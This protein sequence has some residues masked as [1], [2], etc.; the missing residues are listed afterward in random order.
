MIVLMDR[1]ALKELSPADRTDLVIQLHAAV[2][3]AQAALMDVIAVADELKDWEPDG[4][5]SM[6]AWLMRLLAL[7][8]S[9]AEAYVRTG[10]ALGELPHLAECAADG[11][12]AFNKLRALAPVAP[13]DLD[14]LLASE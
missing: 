1:V 3:S 4:A 10:A 9:T 8:R 13:R 6:Q 12:V 14:E 5:T 7:D 2:S 11:R